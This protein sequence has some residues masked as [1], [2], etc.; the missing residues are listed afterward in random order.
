M[1]FNMAQQQQQ[2][3]QPQTQAPLG[4]HPSL[5]SQQVGGVTYF[6]TA[7]QS[8]PV[9]P[10]NNQASPRRNAAIP[11]MAPTGFAGPAGIE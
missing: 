4:F 10:I 1:N 5:V 7:N 3:P 8:A 2:Q 9:A 11:I 6:N